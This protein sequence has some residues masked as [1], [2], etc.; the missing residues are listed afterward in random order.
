MKGTDILINGN[1]PK[2][3]FL[4]GII[5]GAACAPGMCMEVV[6]ATEPINGKFTYRVCTSGSNGDS[7]PTTVLLEDNLQGVVASLTGANLYTAGQQARLY[8]P[9]PGDELNMLVKNLS[10]TAD[11]HAI[12]DL[13]MIDRAAATGKLLVQDTASHSAPF[14]CM[15]TSAALTADALLA[16]RFG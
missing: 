6:P 8:V 5:S 14:T 15:E 1:E 12:G 16:C 4:E 2:G 11:S 7:R 13:L 3:R 10:G 9:Q